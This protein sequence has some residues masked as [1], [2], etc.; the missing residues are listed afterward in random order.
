MGRPKQ[1]YTI[2][3]FNAIK[4]KH[5]RTYNYLLQSA[6]QTKSQRIYGTN[7]QICLMYSGRT[8]K[9]RH[10]AGISFFRKGEAIFIY[11]KGTSFGNMGNL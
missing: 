4:V 1:T 10:S 8:F 7:A 11:Q 6:N 5:L 3:A 9:P 2:L